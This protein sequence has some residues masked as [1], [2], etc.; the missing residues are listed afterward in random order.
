MY[1]PCR[2]SA[3]SNNQSC[4]SVDPRGGQIMRRRQGFTLI[5]L[6]IV[7]G[8]L[9]ILIGLLLPAAQKVREA[10][11]RA[12]CQNNLKQIGL[13]LQLYH[14]KAHAF[15]SGYI[16]GS[17]PFLSMLDIEPSIF[18]WVPP[19]KKPPPQS[20]GWGWAALILP[21]IEQR[22]LA[23]QIDY[24]LP[25]ESPSMLAQRTTK[26]SLYT[27]PSDADTGV[28]MVLTTKKKKLTRAATNSYAA[29][30]GEEGLINTKPDNGNGVFFRNSR[31]AIRD[32]TDGTSSTLAVGERCARF[33]QTPW[34]GVMTAGSTQTTPGAPVYQSVIEWAPPMA[35][36][37]IGFKPLNSPYSEPYD[38]FSPHGNVVHFVFADGSVHPLST[39]TSVP[40]L[41]ALATRAGGESIGAND[42]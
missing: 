32:I 12:K 27:C 17:G 2:E 35:L 40:V 30:F 31:V 19:T 38:F 26:L 21:E 25:V 37:R 42:Y 6:L 1:D 22:N 23:Q 5:E 29:C 15:P 20:P 24:K 13:A 14:D 9:A 4:G 36:A 10:A 16:F 3:Q 33:T 7:V 18:N 41:Q 11:A 8:V 39:T 34:A 28:F